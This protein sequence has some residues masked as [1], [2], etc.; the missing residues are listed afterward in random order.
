[1][2]EQKI[3][4]KLKISLL[5]G[6][7]FLFSS[8][9]AQNTLTLDDAVKISLKNNFDILVAHND[10]AIDKANNTPGNA[11]MLPTVAL[12]GSVDYGITNTYLKSS[13]DVVSDYPSLSTTMLSG[14]AQLSW[15]LYDG[16][17]MF[18]TKNKLTEIQALGE[19]QFRDK[20]LQTLYNVI[21]AYYDVVRQKQ[22][23][24]SINEAMNYNKDRVT[25]SQAGFNAGSLVKT[26]L[27]QAK[28]DLNVNTENAI[29]QQFAIDVALKT[30][31]QLLGQKEDKLYEISDSIPLGY[32]PDKDDLL[33]KIDQSNTGILSY[34][35]QIEIAQLALKENKSLYLPSFNMKAGYYGSQT[36]NSSGSTLST[37]SVGPQIGG[38]LVIPIYSGGETK[39]KVAVA[40]IQAETAGYNLQNIKLQIKTLL[41]NT[42]T[43]FENQQKL[44]KI[45]S[46]N[47]VLAKENILISL[48]RL[49]QGQ[50]TSLEVHLSQED[51]VQSSTR[52]INFRY[53]LKLAETK[54]KQ[55]ISVL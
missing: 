34:Q 21:A 28:I 17:K 8:V 7:I 26:D 38:T 27:L 53:N 20:V 55:L 41:I 45:E 5:L 36:V 2:N 25:I 16:G 1:M 9:N 50:T 23:L 22:Q 32:S 44:L 12:T 30:L 10:A 43:D 46:E 24:I 15:N 37:S 49:K 42:L 6:I 40:K 54:L 35:K 48:E 52:L 19:I 11:G 47:N 31:N 14:G 51:Y 4:N 33:K 29:D 13:P 3:M 18:V 39:R